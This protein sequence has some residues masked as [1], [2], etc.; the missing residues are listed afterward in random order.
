MRSV[1]PPNIEITKIFN[2]SSIKYKDENEDSKNNNNINN[3]ENE[4][5]DSQIVI[6]YDSGDNQP[7][8][9]CSIGKEKKTKNNLFN[10]HEQKNEFRI[11]NDNSQIAHGALY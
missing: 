3:M 7:N 4:E 9:L 8:D 10:L 11:Q 1:V 5:C 6:V 2:E